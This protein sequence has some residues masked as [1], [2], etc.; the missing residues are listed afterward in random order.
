MGSANLLTRFLGCTDSVESE[1]LLEELVWEQSAPVVEKIV[2]SK[3]HGP[4]GE[5]V[6]SEVL[7]GLISRLR[8]WKQSG[9]RE[10]IEDFRAYSAVAAYH[11]CDGHY[12]RLFPQ[13]HRLENQLRYLLGKHVRLALWA[14]AGWRVDLR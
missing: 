2:S 3:I 1:S 11:G 7:A 6:C 10:E 13:R 5:D 12:R 9:E 4:L 14:S 8:E